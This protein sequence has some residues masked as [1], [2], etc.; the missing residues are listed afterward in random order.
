MRN[1]N[2]FRIPI[3]RTCIFCASIVAYPLNLRDRKAKIDTM[4]FAQFY[5][6]TG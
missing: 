4:I 1:F 5:C 6:E 3:L 2:D